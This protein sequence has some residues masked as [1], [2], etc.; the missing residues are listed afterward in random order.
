MST[1]MDTNEYMWIYSSVISRVV[2]GINFELW[3]SLFKKIMFSKT[4]WKSIT[5]LLVIVM[6]WDN[7]ICSTVPTVLENIIFLN[8]EIHNSKLIPHTTLDIYCFSFV[9][10][11]LLLL[12]WSQ[13][14][15]KK[16]LKIDSLIPK[17][18]FVQ[19]EV[20]IQYSTK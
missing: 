17:G 13:I 14:Y 12:P 18:D 11:N 3:I 2:W 15:R 4:V 7:L 10:E 16:K 1:N 5:L 8:N 6:V 20:K 9:R 19:H